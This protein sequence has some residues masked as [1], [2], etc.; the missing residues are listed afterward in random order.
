MQKRNGQ[1]IE[2]ALGIEYSDVRTLKPRINQALKVMLDMLSGYN[3]I[4]FRVQV[5]EFESSDT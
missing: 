3:H 5:E 2:K 4:Q 1:Q